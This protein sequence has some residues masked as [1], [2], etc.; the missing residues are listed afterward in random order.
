VGTYEQ[1][2]L[3][4][5]IVHYEADEREWVGFEFVNSHI[6]PTSICGLGAVAGRLIR[7]AMQKFPQEW[8]KYRKQVKL[9][10]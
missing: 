8:E 3:L 7:Q 5:K 9:G 2:N 6:Q 4:E 10:A 1:A